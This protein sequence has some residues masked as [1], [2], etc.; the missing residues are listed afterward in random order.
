MCF[1][2]GPRSR[3]GGSPGHPGSLLDSPEL[4][5]R[6]LFGPTLAELLPK[7]RRI[8]TRC[9]EVSYRALCLHRH[10]APESPAY[11]AAGASFPV[12]V[13]GAKRRLA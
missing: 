5:F 2:G 4:A 10:L 3:S 13:K 6:L 1:V 12:V 9:V 11:D 8:N 7:F